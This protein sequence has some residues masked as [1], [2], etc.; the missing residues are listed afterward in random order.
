[1]KNQRYALVFR[2]RKARLRGQL[3]LLISISTVAASGNSR[4]TISEHQAIEMNGLRGI[5]TVEVDAI[6]PQALDT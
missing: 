2:N 3:G 1:M 5:L 4:L 6:L